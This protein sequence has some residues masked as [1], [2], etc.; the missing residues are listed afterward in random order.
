M[1]KSR[2]KQIVQVSVIG[3]ITNLILAIIKIII[4]SIS[5]S[6]A[7]ISDAVNNLTDSLSSLITIIGTKL[8]QK[9]PD[10]KHPFG[11]GRIEYLTS[12]IIGM[13]IIVTGLEMV[14]S[15]VKHIFHP[16]AVNYNF[17]ILIILFITVALKIFLATYNQKQGKKLNSGALVASGKDAKNDA[18][19]SSVTIISAI[20][21]MFTKVSVDSYAGL[22]IS[23]FILKSG[24]EILRDNISKILGEKIDA[25]VKEKIY[26]IT[27][28]SEY[29]IGVHDLIL[30]NYGPNINLGS[31]NVEIDYK[32]TVGEIYPELHRLQMKI[33]KETHAYLV[34]GIYG[35]D[36]DSK[37]SKE[38]WSTLKGFKENESHCLGC[39]GIVIDEKDKT[40]FCDAVLDFSCDRSKVKGRLEKMLKDKF[41]EYTIVV[42]ID[43]EFA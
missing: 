38:V 5:G 11:F 13:T 16:G 14:I 34:F 24:F 30:N 4:G 26:K 1:K 25:D 22:F 31:I 35:V 23:I 42:T 3:I 29:V 43:S 36:K 28:S 21:D 39:H 37:I 9:R 41:N 27:Q 6:I 32:K 20:I 12:M 7:I 15:S 40:I 18:I 33:Y 8:A 10:K 2:E 19:V 17:W